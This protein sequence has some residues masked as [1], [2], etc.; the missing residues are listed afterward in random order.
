MVVEAYAEVCFS[1]LSTRLL[2]RSRWIKLRL[3]RIAAPITFDTCVWTT[4][5]QCP[6]LVMINVLYNVVVKT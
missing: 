5:Q 6:I 3:Q 1:A 2:I 4:E